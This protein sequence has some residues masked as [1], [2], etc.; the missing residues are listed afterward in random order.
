MNCRCSGESG[1]S[2][3]AVFRLYGLVTLS[4]VLVHFPWDMLAVLDKRF[5][6][7]VA[8]TGAKGIGDGQLGADTDHSY[9]R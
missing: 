5:A 8:P 2:P 1:E 6:G 4:L 9:G 3:E 7:N